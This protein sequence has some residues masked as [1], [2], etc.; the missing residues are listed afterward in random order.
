MNQWHIFDANST[1]PT[2]TNDWDTLNNQLYQ[3]HPLLDS[4]FIQALLQHFGNQDIKLAVD[5]SNVGKPQNFILL[6]QKKPGFWI[7][8][9]P[10]QAQVAPLLCGQPDTL[11]SLFKVLPGYSISLDILCQDPNYSF[12]LPLLH[13]Y[14]KLHHATTMNIELQGTFEEYWLQRSKNLRHNIKRY[15]N[16]LTKNNINL[17]IENH[18]S[19]SG[20]NKALMRYSALEMKGWKSTKGTAIK[21]NNQQGEFYLDVLESFSKTNQAEIIELYFNNELAASRIVLFNRDMLIILKTTYNEDLS[22]YAPGRLLLYQLIER[23]FVLKRVKKIEFYTNATQDQLS[24]STGKRFI[25]HLTLYRSIYL[26][27]IFDIIRQIKR[28]AIK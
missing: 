14:E 19:I 12:P 15:I 27:N 10:S 5:R 7:T 26:H 4:R 25:Q 22:Q 2:I 17:R 24:W 3:L 8:F 20:L 28:L 11:P 16:K 13:P 21:Y 1:F 18:I 9:L 6:L 23:E